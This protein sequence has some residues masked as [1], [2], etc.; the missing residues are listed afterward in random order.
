[1]VRAADGAKLPSED[2]GAPSRAVELK[3]LW[4]R[5]KD[6][7]LV[8]FE[9][10]EVQ[11]R[12]LDLLAAEY[13]DFDWRNGRYGLRGAREDVLKARQFGMS[14]LILGLL[15]LDTINTPYT[16]TIIIAHNAE[17]TERLFRIVHR[18]YQH[19]PAELKRPKKYSNKRE[20]EFQ[21]IDSGI[22][23][24]TAGA[25]AVGRGGTVNNAL[26][27][28]YAFYEDPE[29]VELGVLEA[30]P[31][32][33]NVWRETTAN[34]LNE[35]YHERQ[36]QKQGDSRF[37]PRFFGWNLHSEYRL[38]A[39]DLVPTEEEKRL[40][41]AYGLDN[42][43]LAWRRAKLKDLGDK[44][45]QEYPLNDAEAFLA[46]G[47]PYYDRQY[48]YKLLNH[49]Q[50]PENQPLK[51]IDMGA[52]FGPDW[53][54]TLELYQYPPEVVRNG[55]SIS[56]PCV[57]GADVAEGIND[58][59]DHD[60]CTLDI[61]RADTWEHVASFWG[62]CTPSAFGEVCDYV[63]RQ[64]NDARLCV[65]RNNCGGTTLAKLIDV[66]YP[67]LYY[68][69]AAR[70]ENSPHVERLEAGYP[71]TTKTKPHV[72]NLLA[73]AIREAAQGLEALQ[74]RG[75][76]AVEELIHYVK[77]PGGKAGGEGR[78]HD[79]HV[80]SIGLMHLMLCEHGH[81]ENGPYADLQPEEPVMLY[82]AKLRG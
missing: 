35:Y 10:N 24:G 39:A 65:E 5:T 30:V 2:G 72:D 8:R 38:P 15:F 28:E 32:E 27:S 73:Q 36:R 69:A 79:D 25:G 9:P 44:F 11:R 55:M 43:Q 20:I 42:A 46:S 21:D 81:G 64:Y 80:S 12:Y 82:G 3:D 77:L 22:Y 59:G 23:V 4:I 62:R 45:T 58:D 61:A 40:A 76:R 68:H 52:A 74:L 60:Y 66:G 71:K 78:C 26:M 16:Q 57:A 13:A 49:L 48:L 14:T 75:R 41:K 70:G 54:G 53:C 29:E 37:R 51:V 19:L 31:M 1:M 50:R 67:N 7:R 63:C 33:G 18:F 56:V 17:L 6:K 34:G 47:N